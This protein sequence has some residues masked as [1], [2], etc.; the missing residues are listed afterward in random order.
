MSLWI[1]E[2]LE[3][4]AMLVQS[5]MKHQTS[6]EFPLERIKTTLQHIQI[7][8]EVTTESLQKW[9]DNACDIG[10]LKRENIVPLEGFMQEVL[11]EKTADL[12]EKTEIKSEKS[13]V[14]V[15]KTENT[16]KADTGTAKADAETVEKT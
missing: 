3:E 11:K 14:M 13:A 6:L 4:A 15:E 12:C 7:E 2:H 1:K 10:F 9:I 5:E 8:T 16:V